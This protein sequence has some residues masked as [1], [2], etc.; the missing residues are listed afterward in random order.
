[1]VEVLGRST[2][3]NQSEKGGEEVEVKE[4][5]CHMGRQSAEKGEEKTEVVVDRTIKDGEEE[6]EGE[7]EGGYT[8]GKQSGWKAVEDI[9]EERRC[10]MSKQSWGE[11]AGERERDPP[12]VVW[13]EE[14][15][16][17]SCGSHGNTLQP[18]RGGDGAVRIQCALL[19]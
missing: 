12:A 3:H 15:W 9:E 1:M 18:R 5:G 14:C 8:I 10:P 7:V 13:C 4:R 11:E 6:G 17:N 16:E 19:P 2:M